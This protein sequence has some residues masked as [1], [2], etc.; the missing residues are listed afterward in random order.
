[1][2]KYISLALGIFALATVVYS[3]FE[4]AIDRSEILGFEVGIWSYR[5]FWSVL[6][7]ALFFS[8]LKE[9][10]NKISDLK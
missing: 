9:S 5:L 10:K 6:T 3:F 4:N 8:F 2:K 7:A 1:M